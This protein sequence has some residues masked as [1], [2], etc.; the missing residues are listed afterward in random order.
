MHFL[1]PHYFC[2]ASDLGVTES[3][4]LLPIG[5]VMVFRVLLESQQGIL[6]VLVCLSICRSVLTRKHEESRQD[7]V[8]NLV[9]YFIVPEPFT[10]ES[11]K[12]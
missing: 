9:K 5:G 1:L 12:L 10:L 11:W 7:L 6:K 4:T 2:I 3:N 8:I